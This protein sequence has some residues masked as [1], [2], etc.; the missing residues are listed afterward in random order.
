[1]SEKSMVTFKTVTINKENFLT[2][3]NPDQ[4]VSETGGYLSY[5]TGIY[6]SKNDNG[7]PN[8]LIDLYTN[9]SSCHQN[10]INLKANLIL[11]NNLQAEDD[12]LSPQLDP[13]LI[14]KNK[15][16][17]N[18]K[19]VYAKASKDMAL[20]NAAVIQ[21]IFNREGKIA[22]VYHVP[23]QNFRLGSP[24]KY[25]QI[26]YGYL[27]SNWATIQNSKQSKGVKDFV[28]IRM[29][30]PTNWQKHAVQLMYVKDYS[31]GHYAVPA[32]TAA[33]NWILI[34]R[35]ISDF[36]LNNIK[37]NFFIG[38]MLTQKKGG[39]TD[40]QLDENAQAIESFY[41]GSKGKKVLLS[42]VEDMVN[43]VPQFQQF[44]GDNQDKLFESL[45]QQSFQQTVTA[46]NAY[47]VLAGVDSKGADLG[48]D[49]NRLLISLQSF[50][51]L[52]TS[53]MKQLL[54]D[55][56]NTILVEVNELPAVYAVTAPPHI[57]LPIQQ[58]TDTTE[59]E[60]R[61]I[62]FGLPAKDDSSNA[63][64]PDGTATTTLT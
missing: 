47:S 3:I 18:L 37:S 16:G 50:E 8:L 51:A 45:S 42:Y 48:G 56:I 24:N 6:G 21:V 36:H 19:G 31:Y 9:G 38:G 23:C 32:Y 57:T 46:H 12:T 20:F 61:E 27:S 28:K 41:K 33:I 15:A 5:N 62:L 59:A 43:D 44:G 14:K 29:Y 4:V 7:F 11:G 63:V 60:R 30:D 10:L 1:M 2:V 64:A 35:E 55:A 25:G 17:D 39:M 52:V 22:E 26:E 40:D 34:N 13:V 53:G 49:V 58:G 54:L